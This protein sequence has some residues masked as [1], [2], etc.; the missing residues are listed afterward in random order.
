METTRSL[1]PFKFLLPFVALMVASVA[2][3]LLFTAPTLE[4]VTLP[5]PGEAT[6][7]QVA[8]AWEQLSAAIECYDY[9]EAL[10]LSKWLDERLMIE[11]KA[12]S[13]TNTDII[14]AWCDLGGHKWNFCEEKD[15]AK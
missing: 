15:S 6:K 1:R 4:A 14:R 3:W 9:D 11:G 7:A 5:T 13:T 12:A 8:K 10:R 2:L